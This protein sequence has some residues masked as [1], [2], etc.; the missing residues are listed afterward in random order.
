MNG[1]TDEWMSLTVS[2]KARLRTWDNTFLRTSCLTFGRCCKV[3]SCHGKQQETPGG[4][5]ACRHQHMITS[6]VGS[7]HVLVTARIVLSLSEYLPLPT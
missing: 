4:F 7:V 1:C 6:I 3:D 2:L 5:I